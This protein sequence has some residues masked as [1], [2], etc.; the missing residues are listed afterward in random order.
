MQAV[1]I[2]G[3]RGSRLSAVTGEL[4]KPMIEIA[5]RPLLEHQVLLLKENGILDISF[6][7]GYLGDVIS[8]HFGDGSR[9][10]VNITY[11]T[12]EQP[13]GTA[14]CLNALAGKMDGDFL[15]CYG[16]IML[17]MDLRSLAA[18]HK[19]KAADAT[20]VVHPNDHPF[21]SDL[22]VMNEDCRI[23][24]FLFK[25]QPRPDY[26]H[27]MVS[28]ALYILNPAVFNYI[29]NDKKADFVKDI[30]P[31]MLRDGKAFY[32]YKTAEYVKDMGTPERL[33]KV[34]MDFESGKIRRSSRDNSRPAIFLDR[35]GT[36]IKYINL[37]HRHEDLELF[38]ETGPAIK[39][40]NASDYLCFMVT[41]QPVV[42]RNIC[43]P[44]DVQ[45]VHRKLET[46]LGSSGAYI[47]DI[48][49]CPHHPDKGYPE[50]N[51]EYK[52]ECS[53]RKPAIGMIEQAAAEYNIDLQASWI[54]GDTSAD[55]Q[56]G[57]NAGLNTVLVRTGM[58]GR[59]GKYEAE[60]DFVFDDLGSAVDFI[61]SGQKHL[62]EYASAIIDELRADSAKQPYV[63]AVSGLA[64]SGKSTFVKLLL[65]ELESADISAEAIS[66][67]NW[68]VDA[69]QRTDDMTVRSRYKYDA[70]N[71]DIRRIIDGEAVRISKYDPQTRAIAGESDFKLNGARCLIIEGVPALDAPGVRDLAD[72]KVYIEIDE[73]KRKT[74]FE[75]FYAWKQLS[76][77]IAASLYDGRLKDEVPIIKE[78]AKCA[79]I[80][81]NI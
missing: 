60:P 40:I 53:C 49:Y 81:V 56:A 44:V 28:A 12:E 68:L 5:G 22:V 26:Y 13:L 38:D 50:E 20:L 59:D 70:I 19:A 78:S 48:Y 18:F 14:G 27:N 11:Y 36:L 3:G 51:P 41:N 21:D 73:D 80:L 46:L 31:G 1:I 79:D 75:C 34:R 29:E 6:M 47:N 24:S 16:D 45:E 64:R 7:L 9:Y 2:A 25:D 57:I 66:L 77:E 15:V 17:N 63:I 72:K 39:A 30:F 62:R 4:P 65:G 67:D 37:L 35:D 76:G 23:Q 10:G 43:S 58:G 32:G 42:A 61:V 69:R 55:I 54:I 8:E 52:I 71:S 33:K 74:R